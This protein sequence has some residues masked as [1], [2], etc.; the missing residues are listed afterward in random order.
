[1]PSDD[2]FD[3]GHC[4][5]YEHADRVQAL[6]A[7]YHRKD[8]ALMTF[9]AR[10]WDSLLEPKGPKVALMAETLGIEG[11]DRLALRK[12]LAAYLRTMDERIAAL[13][14]PLSQ[15]GDSALPIDN[16]A[17]RHPTER[18]AA[19]IDQQTERWAR[20]LNVEP[21]DPLPDVPRN[22]AVIHGPWLDARLI[23]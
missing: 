5:L 18:I 1:L 16:A 12:V 17:L 7:F 3:L 4:S 8:A 10:V 2:A 23:P 22:A 14:G 13:D 15:V 20:L 11:H 6:T 21:M 9:T 19:I